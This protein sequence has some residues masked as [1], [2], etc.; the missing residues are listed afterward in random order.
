[1]PQR[2]ARPFPLMVAGLWPAAALAATLLPAAADAAVTVTSGNG[3]VSARTSIDFMPE[4]DSDNTSGTSDAGYMIDAFA[5]EALEPT[6]FPGSP[7]VEP[8]A[9]ATANQTGRYSV[10]GDTLAAEFDSRIRSSVQSDD[11]RLYTATSQSEFVLEFN[12]TGPGARY[13]L[14]GDTSSSYQ[15]FG[16]AGSATISISLTDTFSNAVLFEYIEDTTFVDAPF[17]LPQGNTPPFSTMDAL[18]AGSYRLQVSARAGVAE[19]TERFFGSA[20]NAAFSDVRFNVIPIPEPGSAIL[21]TLGGLTLLRRRR[22]PR[23]AETEGGSDK[24]SQKPLRSQAVGFMLPVVLALLCVSV[25][26]IDA[27]TLTLSTSQN[28]FFPGTKNQGYW[29]STGY[30]SNNFNDYFI[31][32]YDADRYRNFFTFDIT[33]IGGRNVTA[34]DL[35]LTRS[36]SSTTNLTDELV[37]FYDVSTPA[38][39]L[40]DKNGPSASIYDDLGSGREYGTFGVTR[41]GRSADVLLFELNHNAIS[42]INTNS[43]NFFSIGGSLLTAHGD[44]DLFFN[45]L[46]GDGGVQTLT[47]TFGKAWNNTTNSNH[48]WSTAGNWTGSAVPAA[49]DDAT[50]NR[51]GVQNVA[52]AADAVAKDLLLYQGQVAFALDTHR[53]NLTGQLLIGKGGGTDSLTLRGGTVAATGNGIHGV[54]V[55]GS[56][57]TLIVDGS[58]LDLNG[59][60]RL[61]V[62]IGGSSTGLLNIINGGRVLSEGFIQLGDDNMDDGTVVVDGAGSLLQTNAY[63]RIGSESQGELSVRNGGRVEAFDVSLGGTAAA[64]GNL[65]IDASGGTVAIG[66]D[67][68]VGGPN[69][70]TSAGT[71]TVNVDGGTLDVGRNLRVQNTSSRVN[72]AGGTLRAASLI[73]TAN[74]S[75]LNWT[76]GTLE[77]TGGSL[78]GLSSLI[79]PDG[80]TLMGTGTINAHVTIASGGTLA[81]GNSPGTLTV[82]GDL[83]LGSGS[84][85]DLEIDG[86]AAGAFD[87]LIVTGSFEA[88]GTIRVRLGYTAA[89]GDRFDLLDWTGPITDPQATFDFSDA[90][91]A[92]GLSWDTSEFFS[93]GV[94][95]IIPEPASG[96]LLLLLLAA[97]NGGAWGRGRGV[98]TGQAA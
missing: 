29:S 85:L 24:R 81:P 11:I 23:Q 43:G 44:I 52:F 80:G 74:A 76:G 27:S 88:D 3:F 54:G 2:S 30:N 21:L 53:L 15:M 7:D 25:S 35:R 83:V 58:T 38:A 41:I 42:D 62:G 12:V 51:D 13:T 18:A 50:F 77:L 79:T 46:D 8:G 59:N 45:G 10:I 65:T 9:V 95:R 97:V 48:R 93:T 68:V 22:R 98:R 16:G 87:R 47:L 60:N 20:A 5:G 61:S 28:P 91:L 71:G 37:R 92:G 82:D 33:S 86:T 90:G 39:T 66:R 26:S 57:G 32:I 67:L 89:H 70:A 69:N 17:N 19:R 63:I 40:N 36:S 94:L 78:T 49:T 55:S 64:V 14:T 6:G 31:G 84:F 96:V 73:L 34:A 72:L 1:M 56:S 4:S 75:G